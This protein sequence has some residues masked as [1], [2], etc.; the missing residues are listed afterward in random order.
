MRP[1]EIIRGARR[2]LGDPRVV[3]VAGALPRTAA[4]LGRGK[5]R[6][7]PVGY[8]PVKVSPGLV[9]QMMLDE[10]LIS[11]MRDPK[12]FPRGDDYERAGEEIRDAYKM[13]SERGW[14]SDPSSYHVEPPTP[15]P[16]AVTRERALD[17][18]FEH[19]AFAS[20]YAPHD[21]EPGAVRWEGFALNRVA[22]AY[23]L[24]H[25]EPGRPWLV[26]LHGFG[27]G[28]PLVD[29]RAFRASQLHS[30]LGLNVAAVVLP[31]HGPRQ[32]PGTSRGEGF[33]SI[34]L[35]DSVHG[36][37]QAASDARSVIRWIRSAEPGAAVGVYGVSLGGYVT[38]LVASLETGLACAIAGIPATDIPGL[39][40]R[41]S[42]AHVRRR[43]YETGALGPD[44]DAVHSVVSPLVLEP[45]VA[46]DRRYI[47]AGVG[48]R[49]STAGQARRLWEHWDRPRI[50][51]YP[52]G[53]I[54]FFFAGSVQRFVLEALSESGLAPG[55]GGGGAAGASLS[56]KA[57][58]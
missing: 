33:M 9:A 35:L 51:W 26:C 25:P 57:A 18:R 1:E 3:G 53:H 23:V 21:G 8:A 29:L 5:L 30:Q 31:M 10:V 15:A 11:A 19:V 14:L 43:A 38:A 34:R 13:W 24:R 4:V 6:G 12:L 46:R 40:R 44:A 54:G 16:V 58:L 27:M 45:K 50:E 2:Y 17:Q 55:E 22:H 36:M 7:T 42:P 52:G 32:E 28:R 49:M 47:F 39:Y 41:H 48:D 37:A 56:G 20:A